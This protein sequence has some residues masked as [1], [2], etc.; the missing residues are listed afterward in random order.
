MVSTASAA[1]FKELVRSRTDIVAL[2]GESL[3]LRAER[4]GRIF[5]GLCPFHDDHDPSFQV[6]AERQSYRCWVCNKGGDCFSFVMERENLSFLEA[7]EMLAQ[8]ANLDIPKT[9]RRPG[10]TAAEKLPLYDVLHW[11]EQQMHEYLLHAQPAERARNYLIQRGFRPETI[12]K[13]R[14]G[15]H[16]EAADWLMDRANGK[17]RP[18]QMEA[19]RLIGRSDYGSGYYGVFRDRVMFPICDERARPVAFGGRILP[20]SALSTDRKYLNSSES[21]VFPKSRVVY[22]LNWA[23]DAIREL[24]FAVVVE[25][26][27]DCVKLHQ[28]GFGNALATLGTALTETQVSVMKRFTPRIVL[29]YDGD[30]AGIRAAKRAVGLF[31][32]QDVDLRVLVLP[33]ELDP[34]EYIEERGAESLRQLIAEAPE[35]WEFLYQQLTEEHGVATVHARLQ[36][37]ESLLKLLVESP[38]LEGSVKEG[39][40]LASVPRRLGMSEADVRKRLGDL[41]REQSRAGARR[42]SAAVVNGDTSDRSRKDAIVSLQ[43]TAAGNDLLECEFFQI[44]F[45]APHM[46]E[47]CRGEIGPDDFRS[48]VL[49]E[50]WTVCTDLAEEGVSPTFERMLTRID[51]PDLKSLAVWI[52][53]QARV[54]DVKGKLAQDESADGSSG[55]WSQVLHGMKWRREKSAHEALRLDR[56]SQPAGDGGLT[57]EAKI[58]LQQA[59]QFHQ[60]RNL[61]TT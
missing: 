16:P 14:V 10:E 41:R 46:M 51:C 13:F 27:A 53:E 4:G 49:R 15:Y 8:R 23:R 43:R 20:D 11:A 31:L 58:Q 1:E 26:Y 60:R 17:F 3:A 42:F 9:S 59:M 52:D 32:A 44:L 54:R 48:D 61:K 35:A 29:M 56:A 30:D 55:L 33:D 50:L 57:A 34:D 36:I 39:L 19:A 28:A 37:L 5:R 6:N 7:L 12:V 22:G 47:V 24:G 38:A 40:L 21:V 25:G 2:I 45:T 18:E